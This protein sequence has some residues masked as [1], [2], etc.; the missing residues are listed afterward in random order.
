MMRLVEDAVRWGAYVREGDSVAGMIYQPFA[1]WVGAEYGLIAKVLPDLPAELVESASPQAPVIASVHSWIRWPD[2]VPPARGGHLV[3]V[4]GMAG[5]LIRLHNPSGLPGVSQ[6]DA[7]IS[8]AD[9]GR[10]FAG[11]GLLIGG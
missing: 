1:D 10:F 11:R 8:P 2:R 5:G 3:L 6:Q 7:L 4:T 9:F